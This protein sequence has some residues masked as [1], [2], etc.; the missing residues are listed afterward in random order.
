[1]KTYVDSI[2]IPAKFVE[3]AEGW[4]SGVGDLL[5]AVASTKG[6]TRGSTCPVELCHLPHGD[7]RDKRW[8]LKLWTELSHDVRVAWLCAEQSDNAEHVADAKP[9]AAF[10]KWVDKVVEELSKAY[11]FDHWMPD[12]GDNDGAW[13]DG[14]WVPTG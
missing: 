10:E 9:L 8:Y 5:Y 12:D 4:Y 3:L 6:L 13:V 7:E 11:G 2:K 14:C 1:M